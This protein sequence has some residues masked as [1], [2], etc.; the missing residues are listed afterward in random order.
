MHDSPSRVKRF[1]RYELRIDPFPTGR[2]QV[3]AVLK[4]IIVRTALWYVQ[5]CK[6]NA[7]SWKNYFLIQ[8]QISLQGHYTLKWSLQLAHVP[9]ASNQ[10]A[11]TTFSQNMNYSIECVGAPDETLA[12]VWKTHLITVPHCH[13]KH[14]TGETCTTLLFHTINI[15][16]P[17]IKFY[18][19]IK[20]T[21]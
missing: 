21:T 7:V 16:K 4:F 6:R 20:I 19:K 3:T 15:H 2:P 9:P 12:A 13:L 1:F 10:I 5:T 17:R 14:D 11:I 8:Y 18:V